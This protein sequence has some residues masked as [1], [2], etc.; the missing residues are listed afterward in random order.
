MLNYPTSDTVFNIFREF[1]SG[2][3]WY[4]IQKGA[5][6]HQGEGFSFECDLITEQQYVQWNCHQKHSRWRFALKQKPND[7]SDFEWKWDIVRTRSFYDDKKF[8]RALQVFGNSISYTKQKISLDEELKKLENSTSKASGY[9][10][11]RCGYTY[12]FTVTDDYSRFIL[13]ENYGQGSTEFRDRLLKKHRLL[14]EEII[15]AHGLLNK[16]DVRFA[17][18]KNGFEIPDPSDSSGCWSYF[19][20]YNMK[21]L[22][23]IH[24]CY[25]MA[26]ACI[27]ILCE[28]IPHLD[29]LR[30]MMYRYPV[31]EHDG[32]EVVY[33]SKH[34]DG[35]KRLSNW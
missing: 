19:C 25:G 30:F 11:V 24:E 22:N 28:K 10:S 34:E 3:L 8:D 21:N 17:I 4:E 2:K 5:L 7:G 12:L 6:S 32:I 23:N 18:H 14:L 31:G 20:Q 1:D 15:C 27:Q 9:N 35:N 16:R 29:R 13:N 26:L 33:I